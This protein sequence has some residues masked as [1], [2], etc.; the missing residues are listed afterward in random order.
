MHWKEYV[1]ELGEE[2]HHLL[3]VLLGTGLRAARLAAQIAQEDG[4]VDELAE[5]LRVA[6]ARLIAA[7]SLL[8][9]TH[10]SSP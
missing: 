6:K 8:W 10:R 3:L 7:E 1:A 5:R 4:D 9:L 2:D